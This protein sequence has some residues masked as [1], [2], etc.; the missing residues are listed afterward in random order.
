LKPADVFLSPLK[1]PTKSSVSAEAINASLYYLH[2]ASPD[3]DILLQE[4]EQEREER[5]RLRK[6]GLIDDDPDLPTPPPEIARLNNVR[7][8][9]VSGVP[10]TA[11]LDATP[12]V[13][14]RPLPAEPSDQQSEN[15]PSS[16]ALPPRPPTFH[17]L[18]SNPAEAMARLTE[19]EGSR[20]PMPPRPLP[21]VP[22]HDT[23]DGVRCLDI[24]LIRCSVG[25][26]DLK[27]LLQFD[28]ALMLLDRRCDLP[29]RMAY[30][31]SF[32]P[33]RMPQEV[34]DN[35]LI[36]A[37]EISPLLRASQASILH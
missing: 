23:F 19:A 7:R 22:Q 29:R 13:R 6:E 11:G 12:Q 4:Y 34:Q 30:R 26:R 37:R 24:S 18:T 16:P 25:G 15:T 33:Q 27:G 32:H 20:P 14:R 31:H 8:K 21:G 36:D 35:L 2:V 10:D 5:A 28:T 17:S 3:D 9:P 1:P